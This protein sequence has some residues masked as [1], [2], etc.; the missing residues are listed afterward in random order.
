M[1]SDLV[2]SSKENSTA[3]IR[4][5]WALT[6]PFMQYLNAVFA[7]W[8]D[9]ENQVAEWGLNCALCCSWTERGK[10]IWRKDDLAQHLRDSH[11]SW[12]EPDL[13][14]DQARKRKCKFAVPT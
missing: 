3:A 4:G 1:V 13:S 2:P 10:K 12:S 14:K 7:P 6:Q 9:V 11:A 5:I 8:F